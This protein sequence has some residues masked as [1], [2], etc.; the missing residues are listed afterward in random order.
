MTDSLAIK[1]VRDSLLI[2]LPTDAEGEELNLLLKTIDRR[3]EFFRGARLA[4]EVGELALGA[5]QLSQIRQALAEREVDLFAVLS[6][7]APTLYAASDLGLETNLDRAED[8]EASREPAFDTRLPG[9]EAILVEK[10]LHSG[11]HIEHPGHVIVMGDINP[12]AEVIAGGNVVVWGRLRGVVHAGAGGDESAV[13]CALDLSPTQLRIAA[14]IALSP[15]R[16]GPAQP[17]VARVRDGQ[18]VAESWTTR[19]N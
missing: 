11:N 2:T 10:T 19:S 13:I 3:A 12:G 6:A 18:I 14:Q 17:E 5:N 15:E 1:G 9:Q 16:E 4:L 8:L 7:A